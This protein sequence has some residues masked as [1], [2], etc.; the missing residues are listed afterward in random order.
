MNKLRNLSAETQACTSPKNLHRFFMAGSVYLK[1]VFIQPNIP[2]FS[3]FIAYLGA[4]NKP[5]RTEQLHTLAT[6]LYVRVI[7]LKR[8]V[9]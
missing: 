7:G 4:E 1:S 2:S 9:M 5:K 3:T 6:G 8:G